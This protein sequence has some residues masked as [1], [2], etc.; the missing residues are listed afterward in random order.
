MRAANIKAPARTRCAG[1]DQIKSTCGED[2]STV[3]RH[4]LLN[5]LR[6]G[7]VTTFQARHLL[8]VPHPAGRVN[9]LREAGFHI[10]TLWCDDLSSAGRKHRVARYVLGGQ[11]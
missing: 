5:A 3:Q 2:S 1:L 11:P 8:D 4:R 9:E 6:R 7:P 10:A